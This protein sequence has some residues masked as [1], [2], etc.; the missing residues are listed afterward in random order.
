MIVLYIRKLKYGMSSNVTCSSHCIA[1]L[2]SGA[3]RFLVC[4]DCHLSFEFPAAAHYDTT[5]KQFESHP[6]SVPL[7]AND[8]APEVTYSVWKGAALRGTCD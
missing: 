4:R 2:M 6:C 7:P 8:D 1:I 5:A 3:G